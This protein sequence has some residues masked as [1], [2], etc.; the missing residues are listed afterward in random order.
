MTVS[1]NFDEINFLPDVKDW[2]FG[3]YLPL[4]EDSGLMNQTIKG[5][6]HNFTNGGLEVVGHYGSRVTF[7]Y[8]DPQINVIDQDP[9]FPSLYYL[10]R[11]FAN[12]DSTTGPM[13]G[14]YPYSMEGFLPYDNE[15]WKYTEPG[16][17]FT[18]NEAGGYVIYFKK[19]F[20]QKNNQLLKTWILEKSIFNAL[21]GLVNFDTIFYSNYYDYYV[22]CKHLFVSEPSGNVKAKLITNVKIKNSVIVKVF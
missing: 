2:L 18:N 3:V 11:N 22:Y 1:K 20:G 15:D 4:I 21:V 8:Y 19:G 13:T 14:E 12:M 5:K 6:S 7:R 9:P 16:T 10:K 17:Y